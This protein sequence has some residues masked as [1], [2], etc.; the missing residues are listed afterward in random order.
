MRSDA[1]PE[2]FSDAARSVRRRRTRLVSGLLAPA[3][4]ASG[5]MPD[6]HQPSASQPGIVG[7]RAHNRYI[8]VAYMR[9]VLV[10]AIAS[11]WFVKTLVERRPLA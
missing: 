5:A 7:G 3:A 2:Q 11:S 4:I 10:T 8:P 1:T 9:H 6:V